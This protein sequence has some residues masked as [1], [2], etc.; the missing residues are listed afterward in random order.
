MIT[1][2]GD[3]SDVVLDEP[4]ATLRAR[5]IP[6]FTVGVGEEQFERDIQISRIETP[7]MIL[8]G[9]SVAVDVVVTHT[10][11]AGTRVA[12]QVEDEGRLVSS[13]EVTLPDDGEA[14]TVRVNFTGIDA[15]PRLFRFA[16]PV[17]EGEQVTQNNARTSLIL[18]TDGPERILY[19]EGEPRFETKFIRRAVEDDENVKVVILQR[20][21]EDKYLRLDVDSPDEL[22]SGFPRTREELFA[23]RA[24][25]LGSVEAAAF[26][27]DQIRMLADFVSIRGGGLMMLGGRRSFAEGGW[28]GTPVAEVLPVD[29]DAPSSGGSANAQFFTELSVRAT[30]AGATSP[31]VQL[32]DTEQ[33]SA[34]KWNDLPHLSAVNVVRRVKPG[35]TVLLV[36]ADEEG[37]EQVVLAYQRYGRGKALALPVQDSWI[38]KMDATIPVED[39]THATFWRRLVRWLVEGVPDH[40]SLNTSSDRVEPG[41]AMQ[42]TAEVVD[43]AFVGVN[44]A[45]VVSQVTS[46]SGQVSDVPLEWTVTQDG[47]YRGSFVPSEPGVYEIRTSAMRGETSLGSSVR[48]IRAS[49]GDNEY[50]DAT[51][52]ASLLSRIAEDTYGRFFRSSGAASLPEAINYSGRGV[53]VVEE[54]DLWDMPALLLII[55]GLIAAEWGYRRKRGL[56]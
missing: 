23:Y 11:Y 21:A 42:L 43:P 20:T 37:D 53:T 31:V 39:M 17:Q 41:E 51:M 12:V 56:A 25:I 15:G 1:D 33:A 35:A 29:F 28:A 40:V 36:G 16:V 4:L 6:V 3:T 47:S 49:A 22:A 8:K 34:A 24:V 50:F 44:D 10:G 7:R 30:R 32:A 46:P 52:R 2:G 13:Q 14:A 5:S 55:L 18:V 48:H 27:P 19:M 9:S 54:R 26:S 38:W 45:H